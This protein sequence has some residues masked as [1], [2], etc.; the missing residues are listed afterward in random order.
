MHNV[1]IWSRTGSG[2]LENLWLQI[3]P[4]LQKL[5]PTWFSR[6]GACLVEWITNW[7]WAAIFARG[8]CSPH[9]S[10]S[11]RGCLW[12]FRR[13]SHRTRKQV[14]TQIICEHSH[15]MFCVPKFAYACCEVLSILCELG[16]RV[17]HG[18][19]ALA[20][21]RALQVG[22]CCVK[23]VSMPLSTPRFVLHYITFVL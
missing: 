9:G 17:R 19:Y 20:T 22:L 16:H 15:W 23:S 11:V 5:A 12:P 3:H 21:P 13:R 1:Q 2:L 7:I 6:N 4:I 14:C 8:D 10:R 18:P